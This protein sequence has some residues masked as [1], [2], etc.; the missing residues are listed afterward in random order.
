VIFEFLRQP[1]NNARIL[2]C[3]ARAPALIVAGAMIIYPV[4]SG[5]WLLLRDTGV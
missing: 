5:V 3:A 1:E 2:F 4:R